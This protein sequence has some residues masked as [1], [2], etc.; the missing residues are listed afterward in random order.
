MQ[1]NDATLLNHEGL[2]EYLQGFIT[3]RRRDLIEQ[4][5]S[6]RT[7]QLTVVLENIYH[8]PN[9]SAVIRT[10]D[11]F[12]LQDL[13]VIADQKRFR[14]NADVVQGAAKWVDIQRYAAIEEDNTT[15][16]LQ[17]LKADGYKIAA[18]TLRQE[19]YT[20]LDQIP[21]Q[22]KI[23]VCL[24]CEETGLSD[25][26]HQE[27]D[28]FVHVPMYGF[29]ESFNISVC[30]ALILQ[31]LTA[32]LRQGSVEQWGLQEH[33][34]QI[35]RMRWTRKSLKHADHLIQRYLLDHDIQR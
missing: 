3:E 18:T 13:H 11:C 7:R 12:G 29:T 19:K 34:K 4:V 6:Q 31:Q 20:P 30:A 9:A 5:L 17:K 35:L 33:E 23:A 24:G 2:L 10:C 22:E 27:A 1:Y 8:P 25:T 26:A 28:Y 15:L 14:A 21:C 32:R 16:C